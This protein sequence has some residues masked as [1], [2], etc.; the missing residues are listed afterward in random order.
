MGESRLTEELRVIYCVSYQLEFYEISF[1]FCCI[2]FFDTVDG[3]CFES[4]DAIYD[5]FIP[6]EE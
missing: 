6:S 4:F 2:R 3:Q 5:Y 1:E